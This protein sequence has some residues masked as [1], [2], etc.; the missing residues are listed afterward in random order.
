M[1]D[2][3]DQKDKEIDIRLLRGIFLRTNVSGNT[4]N[5]FTRSFDEIQSQN[6]VN[7]SGENQDAQ[8]ISSIYTSTIRA[9]NPAK[10]LKAAK[11]QVEA[12]WKNKYF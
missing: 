12:E 10:S 9:F 1:R 5:V 4:D 11:K 8:T 6:Q 3:K 2:K 7:G